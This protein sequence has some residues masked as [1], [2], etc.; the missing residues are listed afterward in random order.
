MSEDYIQLKMHQCR[1]VEQVTDH[2][3]CFEEAAL[4]DGCLDLQ[5][6]GVSQKKLK[7]SIKV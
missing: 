2:V 1:R 5:S 7:C 6:F 3:L 4:G